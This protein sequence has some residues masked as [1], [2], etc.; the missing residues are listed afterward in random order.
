MYQRALADCLDEEFDVIN[1]SIGGPGSPDQNELQLFRDLLENGTTVVAAM[2]NERRA[3]SPTSYP[4]AIPGIIAVGA[5][6]IDDTVA[7]FSNRGNHIS[8]CAPGVGIWSTLPSYPGQTEFVAVRGLGDTW[9]Q[10]KPV[11]RETDYDA[12]DGT[13]MASPHFAAA[14]ALLLAK[15]GEMSPADMR[16]RLMSTAH[17]VGPMRG[18]DFDSDYGVG[19]LDLLH[20]LDA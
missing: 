8:L 10:G 12:W 11:Q 14:A 20:L 1:L 3:G 13:S 4:A 15:E 19:R 7:N 17:K 16:D 9:V 6:N 18:A 5:T 2:G